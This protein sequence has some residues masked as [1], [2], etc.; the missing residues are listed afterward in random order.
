MTSEP[1]GPARLT[2]STTDRMVGGVAGGMAAHLNVDTAWIRIAWLA[3][4]FLGPGFLLYVVAWIA[5][6]EASD[7]GAAPVRAT[8]SSDNGRLIVG[9]LLVLVGGSLLANRYVPWIEDLILPAILIAVG[10]GV[11]IYSLRK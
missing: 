10:T 8:R 6:P 9:G 1:T 3:L 7:G 5:I 11:I 2:R 4:L